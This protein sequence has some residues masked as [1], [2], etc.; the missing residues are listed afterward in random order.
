MKRL[1]LNSLVVLGVLNFS[2]LSSANLTPYNN[3]KPDK[4]ENLQSLLEK[5]MSDEEKVKKIEKGFEATFES[6]E[7]VAGMEAIMAEYHS[8]EEV[9]SVAVEEDSRKW[10]EV[11]GLVAIASLLPLY[12]K[13]GI[14]RR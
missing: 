11:V 1:S 14:R 2:P 4:K 9:S 3:L 7:Y 13:Y 12:I 8:W 6:D 5:G 10:I